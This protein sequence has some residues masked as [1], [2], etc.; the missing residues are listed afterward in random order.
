MG[1]FSEPKLLTQEAISNAPVKELMRMHIDAEMATNNPQLVSF[2]GM[3]DGVKTMGAALI[4]SLLGY[5]GGSKLAGAIPVG[6]KAKMMTSAS[7]NAGQQKTYARYLDTIK[8]HGVTPQ[9]AGV[10]LRNHNFKKAGAYAGLIIAFG[11]AAYTAVKDRI[12]NHKEVS[13]VGI[14]N[15]H[16]LN[17]EF[18]KRGIDA[19]GQPRKQPTLAPLTQADLAAHNAGLASP[20]QKLGHF[21][22]A[23]ST[24]AAAPGLA[25]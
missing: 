7:L 14:Q 23:K 17:A 6:E 20:G 16:M 13:A 15:T 3:F 18:E 11:L 22:A 4:G 12:K 2:K 9:S 24:A 5:A 8:G 10:H 21:T 19:D 1:L 25:G